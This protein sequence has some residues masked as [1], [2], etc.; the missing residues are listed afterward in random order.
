[1]TDSLVTLNFAGSDIANIDGNLS[2]QSGNNFLDYNPWFVC[3]P[4]FNA[5]GELLN[6]EEIDLRLTQYSPE[7]AIDKGTVDLRFTGNL[8]ALP[9]NY[10]VVTT[11]D[12]EFDLNNSIV[13]LREAIYAA[14]EYTEI[15]FAD[16]LAGT[17]S[18]DSELGQLYVDKGLKIDGAGVIVLDGQNSIRVMYNVASLELAGLTVT[19][20]Y[21][22]GN[23]GGI[24][25]SGTLTVTN[26]TISGNS[27]NF[28]DG[29]IFWGYGELTLYNTIVVENSG[30]DIY[31]QMG[32]I[33][34]FN[35]L[36]TYFDDEENFCYDP[37]L[38]LF[39]D[40]ENG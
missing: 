28:I 39:V 34:G 8:I 9:V 20:G 38:P 25:N 18:L 29:G 6:R 15:T 7:S 27:T 5:S 37:D 40:T 33:Q 26:S 13:S 30:G 10:S 2:A 17:I 16:G 35:N 14:Q 12:D 31:R 19:G 22:A 1:M 24:Y 4:V 21:T 23:G 11:L 32:T 3:G 36:T